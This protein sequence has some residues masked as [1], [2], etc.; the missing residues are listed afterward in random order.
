MK[1]INSDK[2]NPDHA[3]SV[4]NSLIQILQNGALTAIVFQRTIASTLCLILHFCNSF[5]SSQSKASRCPWLFILNPVFSEGFLQLDWSDYCHRPASNEGLCHSYWLGFHWK[6]PTNRRYMI[7]W[8]FGQLDRIELDVTGIQRG[9]L[10]LKQ[11]DVK[12][13]FLF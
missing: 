10:D 5:L 13:L 4:L 12:D 8:I 1:V 2:L 9:K 6:L 3:C 7:S 11:L